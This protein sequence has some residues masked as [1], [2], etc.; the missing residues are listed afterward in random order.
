M[1][2]TRNVV[3]TSV[4]TVRNPRGT[5]ENACLH[6]ENAS[7]APHGRV[8]QKRVRSASETTRERQTDV[9][10]L[11]TDGTSRLQLLCSGLGQAC[12]GRRDTRNVLQ[13]SVRSVR[14]CGWQGENPCL[15]AE[16]ASD[17]PLAHERQKWLGERQT[18]QKDAGAGAWL[19]RWSGAHRA[20]RV[21]SRGLYGGRTRG[22]GGGY[23]AQ[24][25]STGLDSAWKSGREGGRPA[26]VYVRRLTPPGWC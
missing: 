6:A 13:T 21:C 17:A 2:H 16:I 9:P 24:V 11:C 8:R 25:C 14:N 1:G 22:R 26:R 18:C 20:A 5:G 4:R 12:M 19:W 7:D 23:P 10:S 15:H 3:Q